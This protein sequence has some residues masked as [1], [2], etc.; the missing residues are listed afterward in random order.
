MEEAGK[1]WVMIRMVSVR[2]FLLVLAHPGS[3]GQRAVKQ[4]LFSLLVFPVFDF[5]FSVLVKRL[6][7][8]S[9]SEMTYFVSS[10]M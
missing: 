2:I 6:A 8:K 5:I 10:G 4:L 3:S 9:I 1:D 7:R